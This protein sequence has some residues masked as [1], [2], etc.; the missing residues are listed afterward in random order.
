MKRAALPRCCIIGA[1]CSGIVTAKALADRGIPFDW[2]E[3][4]DRIGGQWAFENP[5]GRSAAYRSLHIDTSKEQL[6]LSDYP[7]PGNTPHYLHHTQVL[8]YLQ[9]YI[10]HFGLSGK[11]RLKT[12]VTEAKL[13]GQGIWQ[14]RLGD[15]QARAYDALFVCNGHH[16]DCR[17]PEPAYPGQFDGQQI[18][19]HAYRDPF[20]PFDFRGKRALVVGMGNSAMDIANELCPRHIAE[21]LFVSTRRGAHIFPRYLLGKPAD[22]GKLYPWLP[23]SLQR[24]VGRRIYHTTVGY[25]E[26]YGLPKPDHRLFE[27]HISVSDT[28]PSYVAAGDI[29]MRPGIRELAGDSVLF[30]DGRRE[31]I[32]IIVWATGYKVSFPFFDPSFISAPANRLPLFKRVMKPGIPNLFFIA[33]AQP[34]ITLFALA[35]RQSKWVAAYLA[36]DYALPEVEEQERTILTDEKK[37]MGRYYASVRHTMQLDQDIYFAELDSEMRRGAKRARARGAGRDWLPVPRVTEIE[38]ASAAA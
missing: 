23:L 38:V 29:E 17:W 8:S 24:W 21:K 2:F 20:T 4:S 19:S 37:H 14:I 12:E 18:H 34:S 26:D 15:G 7:M 28:L 10:E 13:D 27:A 6:Q 9:G 1:G 22:K 5:N 30:E 16:W 25:M 31:K 3:M 35:D 33:L 11:V 36:G 32:D